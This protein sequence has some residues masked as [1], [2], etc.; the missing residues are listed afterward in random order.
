MD[1]LSSFSIYVF[2]YSK[3]TTH[4]QRK[5][6][7]G[8]L[9]QRRVKKIVLSAK[10]PLLSHNTNTLAV[11]DMEE[12]ERNYSKRTGKILAALHAS[13]SAF[14]EER[15]VMIEISSNLLALTNSSCL[16]Q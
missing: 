5:R 10:Q 15:F 7:L 14:V 8:A 11:P 1:R 4:S 2:Y 12:I 3:R 13:H 6:Y 16:E 9:L